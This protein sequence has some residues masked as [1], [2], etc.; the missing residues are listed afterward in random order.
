L[1]VIAVETQQFGP[2]QMLFGLEA[3]AREAAH[4]LHFVTLRQSERNEIPTVLEHLR[5]LHVEGAIIIAPV[6]KVI[7]AITDLQ[8]H[9]PLVIA[10]GDPT[11]GT[12]TVTIDQYEGARLATE[13][14]LG[15]G[16]VTVHH[17]SGPRT[18]IDATER[19]RGWRDA[20]TA[21]DARGGKLHVGDWS[22]QRGYVIGQRLAQD[23]GV[24]AIFAANDQTALGVLRAL[25]EGGRTVPDDVSLV[26]FDDT[27]ESGFYLPPLTTVRQDFAEVGRRCV[28]LLL[29]QLGGKEREQHDTIPVALVQRGST[30]APA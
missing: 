11:I 29:S 26:G 9:L 30:A 23:P 17:V 8:P 10:G 25:H 27:P 7:D 24:T 19:I 14:L 1:G 12:A 16:H 13:H 15:L 28:Q 18:W 4:T 22:A 20:L 2:S 21:H 6:R 5:D 3:A